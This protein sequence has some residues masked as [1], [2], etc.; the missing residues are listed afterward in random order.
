LLV[1][2]SSSPFRPFYR[3]S[4]LFLSQQLHR[5]IQFVAA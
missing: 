1:V 5:E 4:V 3:P 2:A